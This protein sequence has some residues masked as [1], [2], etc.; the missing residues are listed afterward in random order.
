MC[1]CTSMM[2]A[3]QE[4][5]HHHFPSTKHAMPHTSRSSKFCFTH[6]TGPAKPQAASPEET[7]AQDIPDS[8]IQAMLR[9]EVLL[10]EAK[11]H[12]LDWELLTNDRKLRQLRTQ[13]RQVHAFPLLVRRFLLL[14][15]DPICSF[16]VGEIGCTNRPQFSVCQAGLV[17]R[18]C[19]HCFGLAH[20]GHRRNACLHC[21]ALV[22]HAGQYRMKDQWTW[23]AEAGQI[24]HHSSSI[25]GLPLTAS[26]TKFIFPSPPGLEHQYKISSA[27]VLL[28]YSP[29]HLYPH[30]RA[31]PSLSV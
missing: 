10:T 3:W 18:L 12:F 9:R 6:R 30:C 17:A 31:N 19:C 14:L 11:L 2:L 8:V 26:G 25:L 15:V 27:V 13:L 22:R 28:K 23:T 1:A 7:G 16:F 20:G 29:S 21:V 24:V 4:N 5:L